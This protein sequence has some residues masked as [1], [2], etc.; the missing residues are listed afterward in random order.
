M[1]IRL[2]LLTFR[3]GPRAR[4][5]KLIAAG[6]LVFALPFGLR[7]EAEPVEVVA[8]GDSITQG[9]GLN[10]G[11]GL[12]DQL[13]GWLFT[14]G[15]EVRVVNAG[16]S[17]DTTAGGR[18]RLDWSLSGGTGAVILALGGNDMLRGLPPAQ[19]RENL[20]AMLEALRARG[21][22]VLLVGLEAPGNYGPAYKAEFDALWPE[23]A[24]RYDTLLLENI[25]APIMAYPPQER[26]ALGLMQDDGIHPSPQGVALII[27]E[28]G[29]KVLEL[30]AQAKAD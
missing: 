30:I 5:C 12:V 10:P 4:L 26:A 27:H 23:L 28:L 25:Y 13:R 7:A 14:Q 22:P 21:L 3:Y 18:E 8:L 2:P 1:K 11:E 9:Y 15:A 24:A 6:F 29:P 16:V 20:S 19:A 17:G